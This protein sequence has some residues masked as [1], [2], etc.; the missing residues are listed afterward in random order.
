MIRTVTEMARAMMIDSQVV[1]AT[2][3]G[4]SPV[5]RLWTTKTVWSGSRTV[6]KPDLQRPGGP[7]PAPYMSTRG[8]CRVWLDPSVPISGSGFRVFLFMVAF[9]YPTVLRKILTLVHHCLCLFYW[10]PL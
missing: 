9:R 8:F 1:L 4:N 6:Q 2:G 5:V 10:L 3:P 7:N